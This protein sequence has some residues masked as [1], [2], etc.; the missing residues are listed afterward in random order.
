V[1]INFPAASCSVLPSTER[2]T[3][4]HCWQDKGSFEQEESDKKAIFLLGGFVVLPSWGPACSKENRSVELCVKIP[5][6]GFNCLRL[7]MKD[8][9]WLF[10]S[11]YY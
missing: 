10:C 8:I 2:G 9:K 7:F 3:Y 11:N 5:L 4:F 6:D 1:H